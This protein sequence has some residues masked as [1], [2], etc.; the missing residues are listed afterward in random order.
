MPSLLT[1]CGSCVLAVRHIN[2]HAQINDTVFS[3]A[4]LAVMDKWHAA[5]CHCDGTKAI[6]TLPSFDDLQ[7]CLKDI[8]GA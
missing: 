3:K 8:G 2:R 7:Q 5:Y 4:A 6:F 1:R